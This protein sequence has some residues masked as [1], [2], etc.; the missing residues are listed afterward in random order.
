MTPGVDRE[1]AEKA[2]DDFIKEYEAKWPKAT[3]KMEKDRH[4][5][6]AFYAFPAEQ[7][8]H[9]AKRRLHRTRT[10]G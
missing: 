5:L 1:H 6:L 7:W 3:G 8:I 9:L 10:S 4:E 2:F